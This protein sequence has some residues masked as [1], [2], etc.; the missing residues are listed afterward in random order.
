MKNLFQKLCKTIIVILSGLL[1]CN[2]AN[3]QEMATK[4]SLARQYATDK[5]YDKA[6]PAY[7]AIY[8]FAPFDKSVYAEYL[9]VLVAAEKYDDA[10]SL[11]EYMSS[12][13]RQDPTM[14]IDMGVVLEASGKKKQ[15][16]EQYQKA[17]KSLTGE[18][19]STRQVAD[20]FAKINKNKLAIKSYEYSKEL[21][22]NPYAYATEL[23]LLYSADGNVAGAVKSLLDLILTQPNT[24]EDIKNSLQQILQDNPTKKNVVQK[25][26][27]NRINQMPDNPYYAELQMWIF[28]KNGDYAGAYR[29]IKTFDDRMN[30]SGYRILSFAKIAAQ[31]GKYDIALEAIDYVINKDEKS[32]FRENAFQD[33]LDILRI[34]LAKSMPIDHKKLLQLLSEYETF[35]ANYPQ[36]KSTR[37]IRNYAMLQARYAHRPDTA[38]SLLQMA[39]NAPNISR[40][41]AAIL[42]LD[43]GDYYVLLNKV[44]DATLEYAQVDKAFKQDALGE[45][46]R[47]R[48]AKLAYYRG[49]FPW[50]QMQLKVLKSATSEL[51]ANDA[52]YL[53]ILIT[54]NTPPDSNMAALSSFATADLLLF[55][56]KTK[57][58]DKLLDS[59][60]NADSESPLL[61]DILMLRS[62]IAMQEGRYHDAIFFLDKIT[63]DFSDDILGDDALFTAAHI[64]ENQLNDKVT[65]ANY[66]EKLILNYPG[67]TFIQEART[68]F[69]LIKSKAEIQ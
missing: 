45:E 29:E 51:I 47:Y 32:P 9:D 44:W 17:V 34:L 6:I 10:T 33:K 5:E 36:H 37:Y 20:A 24:L 49:D 58:S 3:A 7:K 16:D 8:D 41:F 56:F 2:V 40:E 55:Q 68:R 12:I 27:T 26:I 39:I 43:I 53:S 48:N 13:R 18:D 14:Y 62:K 65:A 4:L 59:L 64:Y 25:Q 42:K 66:Y 23:A 46:A 52:L 60:F 31:D 50:A 38:I 54:E 57:E 19:F 21:V 69:N 61:D 11:V 28:T 35:F 63:Q 15:A 67:S 22:S 30:Q 1:L